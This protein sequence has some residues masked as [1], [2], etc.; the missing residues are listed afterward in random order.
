MAN[1]IQYGLSH[2]EITNKELAKATAQINGL[3]GKVSKLALK[4]AYIVGQVAESGAYKDD[5]KTVVDWCADCFGYG[6]SSTYNM[7]TMAK[8][9]LV[10]DSKG[11]V[12]T[13]FANDNGDYNTRQ[14]IAMLPES[15]ETIAKAIA[16]GAI[17]PSMPAEKIRKI[18]KGYD[19]IEG[20]TM[21][22]KSV[23]PSI[24]EK[25]TD[26]TPTE[27]T[28]TEANKVDEYTATFLSIFKPM[29]E[30]EQA[31]KLLEYCKALVKNLESGALTI[32]KN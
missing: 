2:K 8:R 11:N 23:N 15:D 28:P 18:L 9:F 31:E 32:I 20:T 24:E 22:D 14:L 13:T 3:E 26:K 10:C 4:A 25:A 30:G 27:A 12:V 19:V 7:V 16:E 17:L 5:Y 6:K 21:E 1:V 29:V